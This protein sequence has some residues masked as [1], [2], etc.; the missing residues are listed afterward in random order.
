MTSDTR[1]APSAAR[2]ASVPARRRRAD[3]QGLRAIASLLVASYH[4][5]FGT[6]SGGVDVFFA[7]G[8]FLL[9][10][11]LAGE[12]E[13][14]GRVDVWGGIRRQARRLF[15][16]AAIVLVVVGGLLLALGTPLSA[17]RTIVDVFASATYWENWR[18][19]ADATDYVAAGHDKSAFQHFWAMSAQGQVTLTLIVVF[20]LLGVA[21]AT[22]R[23]W[24]V[25]RIA[26]VTL[27]A[28]TSP[29]SPTRSGAWSSTRRTPTSTRGRGCGSSRS[30]VSWRSRSPASRSDASSAP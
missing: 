19:A 26:A 11:S 4:V 10:H 22:I 14:S 27:A 3:I 17:Q 28:A 2:A 21:A 16:M 5:W 13:R 20:A 6:V 23:R 30:A 15:P 12:L 8:G 18:L 25:V 9:V 1:V 29:R 24:S 7:I